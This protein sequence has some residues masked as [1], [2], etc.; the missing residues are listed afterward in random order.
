MSDYKLDLTQTKLNDVIA[1]RVDGCRAAGKGDW[2]FWS[3]QE[4]RAWRTTAISSYH[5]NILIPIDPR[6]LALDGKPC[7][8]DRFFVVYYE[9]IKCWQVCDTHYP[10]SDWIALFK[11]E[12]EA[13]NYAQQLN[14]KEQ[15]VV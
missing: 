8:A 12:I 13:R 7:L 15:N 6:R 11:S 9:N 1:F 2:Y 3:D 14:K 5:F 4:I 10:D